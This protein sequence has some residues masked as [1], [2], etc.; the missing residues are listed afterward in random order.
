VQVG[1]VVAELSRAVDRRG[2]EEERLARS[3]DGSG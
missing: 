2:G 1:V 3:E